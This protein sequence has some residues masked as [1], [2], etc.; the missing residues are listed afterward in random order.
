MTPSLLEVVDDDRRGA[1]SKEGSEESHPSEHGEQDSRPLSV[2]EV[3][4]AFAIVETGS[5][6]VERALDDVETPFTSTPSGSSS[7]TLNQN[8]RRLVDSTRCWRSRALCTSTPK[9]TNDPSAD[10]RG[11][12]ASGKLKKRRSYPSEAE[13][14]HLRQETLVSQP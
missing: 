12:S 9:A 3:E 7:S 2:D 14:T 11:D 4:V 8:D 6:V 10:H 13:H 5:F 1:S